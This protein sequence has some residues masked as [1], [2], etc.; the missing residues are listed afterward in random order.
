MTT[1]PV[2]QSKERSQ[3]HLYSITMLTW[4]TAIHTIRILLGAAGVFSALSGV[5]PALFFV[6]GIGDFLVG[7]IAPL[8]TFG[9][10]RRVGLGIWAGALV[11]NVVGLADI[12][13]G[14]LI[15]ILA[16]TN[17]A[18]RIPFAIFAFPIV[19]SLAH[20]VSIILLTRPNAIYY[21]TQYEFQRPEQNG[22]S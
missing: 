9:L 6:S 17:P 1:T 15:G 20:I 14:N 10:A 12:I 13:N 5:G 4:L 18:V 11:W 8:I 19:L 3:A 2:Q 22:Q 7:L 21:Y 16:P